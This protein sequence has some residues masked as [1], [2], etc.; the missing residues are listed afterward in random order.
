MI[1]AEITCVLSVV[2]YILGLCFSY[3]LAGFLYGATSLSYQSCVK[4][5]EVD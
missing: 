4:S 5:R 2:Q 1:E 3:N